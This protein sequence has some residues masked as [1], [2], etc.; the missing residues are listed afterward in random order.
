MDVRKT[1]FLLNRYK[2]V[3]NKQNPKKYSSTKKNKNLAL[4]QKSKFISKKENFPLSLANIKWSNLSPIL[5]NMHRFGLIHQ[6]TS[7]S[8]FLNP[9]NHPQFIQY[10]WT[11]TSPN[12]T[13][14]QPFPFSGPK[15]K[16]KI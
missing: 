14:L 6:I 15:F 16:S 8:L 5:T 2:T 3:H 7:F 1:I 12:F 10:L 9:L 4:K 11:F 13:Q